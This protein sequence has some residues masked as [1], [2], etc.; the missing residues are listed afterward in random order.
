MPPDQEKCKFA[1]SSAKTQPQSTEARL[2]EKPECHNHYL[3]V[4]ITAQPE[5]KKIPVE[6][7]D[8]LIVFRDFIDSLD[9]DDS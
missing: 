5:S 3:K 1:S 4:Y 8:K 9:L 2:T 6:E 7:E